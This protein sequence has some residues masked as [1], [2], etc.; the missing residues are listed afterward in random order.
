MPRYVFDSRE[1]VFY[2]NIIE[3]ESLEEAKKIFFNGSIDLK[4]IDYYN[5]ELDNCYEE[6][7]DY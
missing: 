2:S 3:A 4:P 1:T 5:F 6:G 7:T